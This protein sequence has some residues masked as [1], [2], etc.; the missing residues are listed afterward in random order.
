MI[1]RELYNKKIKEAFDVLQVVVLTGARQVGKTTIM[2]GYQYG[3]QTLF[4]NG[5]NPEIIELFSGYS[6]IENYLKINLNPQLDGYLL[7]D[8]FQY[9]PDIS[10]VIKLLT[11]N[12]KNL[13]VITTGSSSLDIIQNVEE[14]MA[15]RVRIIPVYSLSF[16]EYIKFHDSELY[17]IYN[18]YDTYTKDEVIDRKIK[19]LELNYLIYGGLPRIALAENNNAKIELLND[20]YQT[21]LLRDIRAFVNNKDSVGFNK[22]LRLLSAQISNILNVNTMSR[23]TGLSYKKTQEYLY[24]LE[25][26]FI[27]KQVEPYS[28]NRKNTI[29]KMKKIYFYDIGMRNM[30]YNSFNDIFIRTDNGAIF[31]NYVF[32]ELI[33]NTPSFSVLNYY[34]TRDGAEVDFVLNTMTE[35]KSFEVKFKDFDK[36]GRIKS[37][38]TFNKAENMKDSY[39]INLN[40]NVLHN[41][42]HYLPSCLI[43]K[44]F[45]SGT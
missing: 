42:I 23:V 35:K 44:V 13:K 37:L 30:I 38:E 40:L 4:I 36:P 12:N 15:G 24:L 26:M 28:S 22:M 18:R 11:D 32:L 20:I 8:E 39:L 16:P 14:S 41:D 2:N 45:S 7:I 19:L 21:Y 9:I 29:T 27:I 17:E 25:Q 6:A 5:Q 1:I 43:S 34:R 33:K 10:T 31:E 3:K